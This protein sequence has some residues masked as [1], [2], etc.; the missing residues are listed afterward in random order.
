MSAALNPNASA[1]A[2]PPSSLAAVPR[3]VWVMVGT[4]AL[5]TAGLAGALVM[6]SIDK[7]EPTQVAA[8]AQLAPTQVAGQQ[9]FAPAQPQ[10]AAPAAQPEPAPAPAKVARPAPPKPA[11]VQQVHRQPAPAPV[12]QAPQVVAQAPVYAPPAPV[13]TTRAAICATCGTVLAVHEVKEKGQGTGLGA[14][15]GALVGG[16]LGNQV[17]GGNGKKAMAVVGA[18][19][20]GLA[21]HEVEK[22]A[23]STVAYDVQ[24]R[25]EDGSVRTLRRSEPLAVG[26]PVFV[27]GS[28]LRVGG[29]GVG[30]VQPGTLRTSASGTGA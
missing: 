30:S 7:P 17:G 2:T 15:G 29:P 23:R 26:T 11:P 16:L 12:Q 21:G 4:L 25:M 19:G 27:E 28:E 5:A 14:V 8:A 1:S 6:R 10:A 13:Q 18:V 3:A 22:R 9:Q 20:G 24:V